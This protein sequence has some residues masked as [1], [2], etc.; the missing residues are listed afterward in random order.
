MIF[1][2]FKRKFE[3][4]GFKIAWYL[5]TAIT[6]RVVVDETVAIVPIATNLQENLL[7]FASEGPKSPL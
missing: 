1:C 3:L 2:L 6:V 4:K 5:S 7:N